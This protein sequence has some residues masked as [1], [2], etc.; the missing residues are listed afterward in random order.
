MTDTVTDS[1]VYDGLILDG[2]PQHTQV[3]TVAQSQ[4]LLRGTVVGK[5]TADGYIAACDHTAED[6]SETPYGVMVE[7]VTTTDS[8]VE[9]LV[10]DFGLFNSNKLTFGGSSTIDDLQDAM[11]SANLYVN[12][13]TTM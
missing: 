8:E 10:Y 3:V 11:K 6:G 4:T 12:T 13:P 5:I 1:L 9:G 7:D 2:F